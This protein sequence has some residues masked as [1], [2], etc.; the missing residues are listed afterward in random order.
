MNSPAPKPGIPDRFTLDQANKMLPLVKAIVKDLIA[1]HALVDQ[2]SH[3][4]ERLGRVKGKKGTAN[5]NEFSDEIEGFRRELEV[6]RSSLESFRRELNR[7]GVHPRDPV[8][9]CDFP[10]LIDGQEVDLCW[11][12]EDA[13]ILF[14]H[15]PGAD[16]EDRRPVVA[17]AGAGFDD[18]SWSDSQD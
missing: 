3:R 18:R 6:E 1:Q 17:G 8:G 9:H 4:L 2:L 14:W 12:P 16:F 7:L 11:V 15:R 5:D 13:E 10:G